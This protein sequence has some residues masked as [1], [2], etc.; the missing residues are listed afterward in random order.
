MKF[1]NLKA[2]GGNGRLTWAFKSYEPPTL[3]ADGLLMLPEI[4]VTVTDEGGASTNKL[5]TIE[6]ASD[7][8]SVKP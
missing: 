7:D 8:A 6:L 4:W 5:L 2:S 1:V 3:T